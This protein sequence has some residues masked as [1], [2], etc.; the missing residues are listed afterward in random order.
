M[1]FARFSKYSF[2]LLPDPF[3]PRNR[4]RSDVFYMSILGLSIKIAEVVVIL[5]WSL[6]VLPSAVSYTVSIGQVCGSKDVSRYVIR[7]CL[8]DTTDGSKSDSQC[9]V[10]HAHQ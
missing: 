2:C 3:L 6:L 7:A 4:I 10:S 8:T 9:V 5:S 1:N